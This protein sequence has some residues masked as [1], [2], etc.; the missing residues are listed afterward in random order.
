MVIELLAALD[1]PVPPDVVPA[2]VNVYVVPVVRPVTEIGE[3]EPV[4]VMPPG[5]DVAVYVT[6]PMPKSVGGVKG[7]EA[8]V[9][10]VTDAVPIVGAPGALAQVEAAAFCICACNVNAPEYFVIYRLPVFVEGKLRVVPG[11]MIRTAPP[12]PHPP[13]A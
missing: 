8:V 2:T 3:D 10:F 5:L 7:T 9:E 1:G 6:V 13:C 11:Q 4:A 12:A